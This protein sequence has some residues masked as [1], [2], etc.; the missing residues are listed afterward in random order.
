MEIKTIRT[1]LLRQLAEHLLNGKLGH[2]I[3]D[4]NRFNDAENECGTCGCAA[5]ELPVIWPDEWF[6]VET[7]SIE[8]KSLVIEK[9]VKKYP[10]SISWLSLQQ[11]F[12]ITPNMSYHLFSPS[13]WDEE[14]EVWEDNNQMPELFG[15]QI[16]TG[17]STKQ[18]VAANM[19]IFCDKVDKGEIA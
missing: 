13:I 4:F 8:F 5:G 15:G 6:F 19:L 9:D 1:D 12:N 10:S 14:G 17:G 2:R 16:L 18:E 3:F 11:F 7:N